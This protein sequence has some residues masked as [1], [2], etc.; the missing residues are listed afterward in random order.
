MKTLKLI[1]FSLFT[2]TFLFSQN[3]IKYDDII[4]L[5]NQKNYSKAYSLLFQFQQSNP[6]F[7]NTYF[8]LANIS[9][10][11]AINSD[12]L[13]DL[14]QTLYYVYNTKL[15]YNL[16]LS[17]LQQDTKDCRKNQNYYKTIPEFKKIDKIEYEIV[18]DYIN[19]QI[20]KIE[21][22]QKNA[23]NTNSI[24]IKLVDTYNKTID[25][26]LSI[27]EKHNKLS[28][29]YLSERTQTLKSTNEL[30]LSYDSSLYFFEQYKLSITNYPIKN[31]NQNIV[32]KPIKIYRLDGISRSNF[33]IDSILIWD[34]K[35]WAVDIQE[36]LTGEIT[37]FRETIIKTNKELTDKENELNSKKSHSNSYKT[38]IID[39]KVINEIEKYDYNSMITVLFLFKKAKIDFLVQYKKTYNDTSNKT[40][41]IESKAI[42][43]YILTVKKQKAD[44]LLTELKLKITEDNYLKYKS[45]IDFNYQGFNGLEKYYETQ[46]KELNDLYTESLKNLKYFTA[47]EIFYVHSNPMYVDF[48]NSKIHLFVETTEPENAEENKYYTT[49][50][51][52]CKNGD[53]YITGYFKQKNSSCAFIAKMSDNKILWLNSNTQGSDIFEYGTKIIT[54][55]KNIFLITHTKTN[56]KNTNYFI[57]YDLDGKQLQ[58]KQLK[59]TKLA[60]KI[61]YDEINNNVLITYHGSLLDYFTDKKDT[62]SIEKINLNDFNTEWKNNFY[63]DADIINILKMDTSY[64]LLANY[65]RITINE[66][67]FLNTKS[68]IISIKISIDGKNLI[69]NE[70]MPNYY[71]WGIYAYKI[72]SKTINIIGFN[73]KIDSKNSFKL[74]NILYYLIIDDKNKIIFQTF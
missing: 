52:D 60:R 36:N 40:N 65:R 43:Y 4:E 27:I 41:N 21:E 32:I 54:G 29:I 25:K 56:K 5:I 55:E 1:I 72:N 35:S 20:Q 45:F 17:K 26:F 66:N 42:E 59:N 37:H 46:K 24:F 6:E 8:Q 69:I 51:S 7:P 44:S 13:I 58:K 14:N 67:N 18:V 16:C 68:N 74:S 33:L 39:Q 57:K 47:T 64:V 28:D 11:W 19:T 22:Y 23:E 2:T 12:P 31:Y 50:I 53:K 34:Y 63:F 71:L 73:T 3:T 15:F 9:Y 49:D 38:Y 10:F 62:V 48:K 61:L 30:I 70:L